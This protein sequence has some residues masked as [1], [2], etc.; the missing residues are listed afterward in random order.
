ITEGAWQVAN[1]CMQVMG[2]IGY[3]NVFPIERIVRDIRLSMI[4]VGTNEIM[5][6]IIQTEWYKEHE[7]N[8]K[9]QKTREVEL[10]AKAAFETEEKV[11]E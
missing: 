3:T 2:G 7:K 6:H 8:M 9:E 4:W 5:Q 11:Y 10:D 1:N